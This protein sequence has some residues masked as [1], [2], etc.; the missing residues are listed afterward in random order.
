[1]QNGIPYEWSYLRDML[2]EALKAEFR[3]FK[4]ALAALKRDI[5]EAIGE[6]PSTPRRIAIK[7][8]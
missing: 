4:E 1:M 6:G 7:K 3:E 5:I 8:D 2:A